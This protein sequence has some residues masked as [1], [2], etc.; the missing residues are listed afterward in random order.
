MLGNPTA[1]V[2]I[3]QEPIAIDSV[4]C[5]SLLQGFFNFVHHEQVF[6]E[7]TQRVIQK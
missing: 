7:L 2:R 3:V 1:I 4:S 6:E 5:Y